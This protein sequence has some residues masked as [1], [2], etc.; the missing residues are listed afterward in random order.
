LHELKL[1]GGWLTC[2]IGG[3]SRA[4]LRRQS[5]AA[6]AIRL[7]STSSC[8]TSSLGSS[9]SE[10]SPLLSTGV[11]CHAKTICYCLL[12]V[13]NYYHLIDMRWLIGG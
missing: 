9:R 6:E 11:A 2:D 13:L 4:D 1:V 8:F 7:T 12:C 10:M 3:L 5:D